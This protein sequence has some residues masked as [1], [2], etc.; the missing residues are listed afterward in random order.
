LSYYYKWPIGHVKVDGSNETE[1]RILLLFASSV[2]LYVS[3]AIVS[4][5]Y[6]VFD[7]LI[8]C[9]YFRNF[10]YRSRLHFAPPVLPCIVASVVLFVYGLQ[11]VFLRQVNLKYIGHDK[12][13]SLG[14]FAFLIGGVLILLAMNIAQAI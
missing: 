4:K 11:I 6:S 14:Y 8:C 1:T 7:G 2:L 3:L 13:Y 5:Y 10:E 9:D 12:D